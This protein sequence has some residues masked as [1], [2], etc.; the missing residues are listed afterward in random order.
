MKRFLPIVLI[1]IGFNSC[2]SFYHPGDTESYTHRISTS[3]KKI[4]PGKAILA[5]STLISNDA[6]SGLRNDDY[7]IDKQI[8]HRM[9]NGANFWFNRQ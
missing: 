9:S 4:Q 3:S 8:N 5:K 2:A 6:T 7:F 1:A